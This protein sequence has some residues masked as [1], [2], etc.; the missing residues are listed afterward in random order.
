MAKNIKRYRKELD[1]Q[2]AAGDTLGLPPVV[3][4]SSL[5]LPAEDWVPVTFLLPNDYSLFVEEFRRHPDTS[6]IAKPTAKAQGKG[7]FLVSKL[8]QLKKWSPSP[9]TSSGSPLSFSERY[10][11]SRYIQ[12]PLLVGGK[13]FDLR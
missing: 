9:S 3:G 12:N 6:W 10:V 8:N 7:I 1:R 13:K 5:A 4:A 2:G 11:V